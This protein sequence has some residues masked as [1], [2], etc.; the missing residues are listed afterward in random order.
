MGYVAARLADQSSWMGEPAHYPQQM[1]RAVNLFL[2]QG[3]AVDQ[4][5][6][7][8][9]LFGWGTNVR[10]NCP[11]S[12]LARQGH[13]LMGRTS[14]WDLHWYAAMRRNT[15][16]QDPSTGYYKSCLLSLFLFDSQWSWLAD[17]HNDLH[18]VWC[19]WVS[20]ETS[21]KAGWAGCPSWALF[22]PQMKNYRLRRVFS[23]QA[24]WQHRKQEPCS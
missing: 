5:P 1:G 23:V 3:R 6:Q 8:L 13:Q 10:Q 15:V 16:R 19:Q 7:S 18:E 17:F 21:Y 4:A 2:C 14:G 11:L 9:K 22:F 12:S 20:W 24:L